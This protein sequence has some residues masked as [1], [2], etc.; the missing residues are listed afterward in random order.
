MCG[1][2]GALDLLGQRAFPEEQLAR[3]AGSLRHRGPDDGFSWSEPGVS[4]ATRRLALLD[5]EGG[6]QPLSDGSGRVWAS[7]NGELFNHR[8]LRADLLARG[9]RLRTRCDTE[10]WPALYLEA[11]E[12]V[13]ERARGQFAAALWDRER[14]LL[15]LGRDRVGICPLYWTRAEGWLLWASEIKAL[16]AS[17]LVRPEADRE[18]ID[19]VFTLFAAGTRRTCFKGIEAL[20]PGHFLRVE[21]G[22]LRQRRY[23]DLDFPDQGQERRAPVE[24]LEEEVAGCLERAVARRLDADVPVASYLSGGLD[25]TLLLGLASRA[26][27]G[28]REAFTVGMEGTGPDERPRTERTAR[29]LGARLHTLVPT[30][31]EIVEALPGVVEAA[32][33]PVMDTAN[34]CL[35]LLSREVRRRG[36]KAVLTG[37]GA[38]EA[39]GGYVWHRTHRLLRGLEALHPALPRGLRRYVGGLVAPGTP[40][41]S[42]E[43][44][45]RGNRPA[46]LDVYEPLSRARWQLYSPE[47]AAQAREAQPWAGLDIDVARMERWHPL[48]RSLYVEYK[49]MLPG[50]LLVGKG[51]RVAMRSSVEARYPFLDEDFVALSSALDPEVK[52]RGMK[53]KWLLRR[54]ARR[55]LPPSL[56]GLPKSMFKASPLCELSPLP[57][58]VDQLVSPESL[59][60]TGYFS[61][62]KIRAAQI[63]Q[64]RHP[65]FAPSRFVLD[66]TY[67]AAVMTQLWHHLFLGGT[68]C[69]LPRWTPPEAPASAV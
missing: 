17:G 69:E 5:E 36:F 13:F 40:E 39:M 45:F 49:L 32:E 18:G 15:L 64:R 19:H 58:W 66:G 47:M 50:H 35:L 59:R 46:L 3:M 30:G 54:V 38:D 12:E 25:S 48:N 61:P 44:H 28:Q 68:L 14:R 51:D 9:H 37:E 34:A 27:G 62:E 55:L 21:G 1:I 6:R 23:W 16:L 2:V 8:E 43:E 10:L 11:G 22:R 53:E 24:R 57:R 33:G 29:L 42:F 67:T 31:R 63:L 7:V 52:L 20:W 26:P 60:A 41:P 65:P 56:A 4:L